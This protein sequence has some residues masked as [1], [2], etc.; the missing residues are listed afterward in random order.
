ME[1]EENV[2]GLKYGEL[3]GEE[4]RPRD[5]LIEGHCGDEELLGLID[6]NFDA[7]AQVLKEGLTEG[8][9]SGDSL[10]LIEGLRKNNKKKG[11]FDQDLL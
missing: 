11:T 1:M 2:L 6:E 4:L 3:N 7:V 9:L 10:G 5:D 8:N